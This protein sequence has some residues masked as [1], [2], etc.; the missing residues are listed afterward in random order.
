MEPMTGSERF[1]K[2]APVYCRVD[3]P[4][5]DLAIGGQCFWLG[6]MRAG[7]LRLEV[8]DVRWRLLRPALFAWTSGFRPAYWSARGWCVIRCTLTRST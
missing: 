6:I 7:V 3:D 1:P 5:D 2:I 4:L 8:G